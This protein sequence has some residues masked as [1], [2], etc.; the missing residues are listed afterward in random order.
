MFNATTAVRKND[1]LFADASRKEEIKEL[2]VNICLIARIQPANIDSDVGPSYDY[3]FLSEV[4]TP[5]TSYMN[6]LFAKDN[7]EQKYLKQTIIINN[8]IDNNIMFDEPNGDVNSSSVEDDNNAQQS[9]ELEQLARNTYKETKKQQIIAKKVQQQN[10][11]LIRQ[12][13]SYKEK[14]QNIKLYDTSCLDDSKIQ[15]NVKDTEDILDD[16]TK[17]QI[18]VKRKSQDP[19]ATEKNQNVWKIDYKKLNALYEDFVPQKELSAKQK[20]FPSSFISFKN[21]SNASSPYSSSETKPT[22]TPMPS[23]NP[24]FVDLN[25]IENV[26]KTLFELLQMNSK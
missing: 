10:T 6:P 23:A 4:Q 11:M 21:C 13:E 9:Y 24:L 25:K 1:F 3:A 8:I 19:I 17:S 5:S 20:Y 2:S 16:A 26:F 7:Q 15:M 22:V 12:L 18:K 14:V